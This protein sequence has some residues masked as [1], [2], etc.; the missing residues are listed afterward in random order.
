MKDANDAIRALE[1]KDEVIRTLADVCGRLADLAM[2]AEQPAPAPVTQT[3]SDEEEGGGGVQCETC[4]VHLPHAAAYVDDEGLAF[5]GRCMAEELKHAADALE[6]GDDFD[7]DLDT[8][9][10]NY[11][12]N[13]R[14]ALKWARHLVAAVEAIAHAKRSR[15]ALGAAATDLQVSNANAAL[16]YQIGSAIDL[17]D[18]VSKWFA[19]TQPKP[20]HEGGAT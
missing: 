15:D 6:L 8:A 4:A 9:F 16:R 12:K 5:C 13:A 19:R 20:A 18:V 17:A 7:G 11:G 10:Q 3:A 14:E 2:V 1:R